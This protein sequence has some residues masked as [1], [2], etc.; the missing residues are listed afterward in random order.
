M[1]WI[2]LEN[3]VNVRD[4]GE[5]PTDDGERT[6]LGR[7]IRA[8]NLQD[9]S[10]GD[11]GKLLDDLG[12]TTVVDL[13]SLPEVES[14]GPGPLRA[15]EAVRH[16]NLSMLPESDGMTDVASDALATNRKRA[17]E[18]DPDDLVV[19]FYTGYL[20]DRPD[21]VVGALRTIT[22]A[23]GATL[24]HC[25]AGKD[26][27]GVVVAMALTAVG[28]SRDAVVADYAATGERIAAILDRLRASPTY[29]ADIDQLPPH[30]HDPRPEYMT[31]FLDRLDERHGGVLGWLDE[32]GFGS[33]DVE[34]LRKK[35]VEE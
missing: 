11:V 33:V 21:S 3:A 14:E 4:V 34:R 28:V 2:E 23:P 10:P 7:L 24:V 25:A 17:L 18:R 27:T 29:A 15:V 30:E 32:H 16:V 6:K 8:D 13:R 1:G 19:A 9:L 22:E 20:A 26:R 35:L 31:R 5:L 12:L